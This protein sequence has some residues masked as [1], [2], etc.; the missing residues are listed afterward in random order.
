MKKT[1]KEPNL[2]DYFAAKAMQSFM[3]Q[4]LPE[5]HSWNKESIAKDSY[6]MADVMLEA[7]DPKEND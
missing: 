7:R 2:R 6:L 1:I 5:G 4:Q 3:F